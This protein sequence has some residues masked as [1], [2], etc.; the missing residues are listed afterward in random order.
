VADSY[1]SIAE[2]IKPLADEMLRNVQENY[3]RNI[4]SNNK[5]GIAIYKI[6]KYLFLS[7]DT[8]QGINLTKELGIPPVYEVP[9][10]SLTNDSGAVI[11]QQFFYGDKDGMGVFNGFV[12][13]FTNT[14]WKIDQ[15]NKQW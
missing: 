13:Q 1:A 2:T 7:A 3:Q 8:T 15:S 6:L 12:K 10:K 11:I 9:Y 14:N 4:N 5:K